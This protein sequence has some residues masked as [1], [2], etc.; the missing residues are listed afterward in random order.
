[1]DLGLKLHSGKTKYDKQ[2]FMFH[3]VL[4]WHWLFRNDDRSIIEYKKTGLVLS[5]RPY[6]TD[7]RRK[8]MI[9]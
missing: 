1:M 8:S 5:N 9:F 6:Y 4:K 7:W 3:L 2:S